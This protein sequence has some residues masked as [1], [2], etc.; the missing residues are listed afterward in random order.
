MASPTDELDLDAHWVPP[1]PFT[2]EF[3]RQLAANL[4][5]RLLT[6]HE[7]DE[8]DELIRGY[9]RAEQAEARVRELEAENERLRPKT[10]A[11]IIGDRP[12]CPYCEM[13][14]GWRKGPEYQWRCPRCGHAWETP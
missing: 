14:H 1:A 7:C 8:I 3:L 11:E 2:D 12:R 4:K 6:E 10:A 5:R 9:K 13:A